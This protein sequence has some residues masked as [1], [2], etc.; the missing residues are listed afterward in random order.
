MVTARQVVSGNGM[1]R[2]V[3][4]ASV[5]TTYACSRDAPPRQSKFLNSTAPVAMSI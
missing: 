4:C 1:L 2:D 3:L 5:A